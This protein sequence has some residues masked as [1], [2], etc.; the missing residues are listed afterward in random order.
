MDESEYIDL[1]KKCTP[2]PPM[3]K[4]VWSMNG[5][6]CIIFIEF[7]DLEIMETNLHNLCNIY[8]GDDNASICII[9]SRLNE[10]TI[11]RVT[12][13]WKNVHYVVPV[14]GNIDVNKYSSMLCSYAFWNMFSNF[15]HILINAWDSYIFKKIPESFFKYDYVG[16]PCAHFYVSHNNGLMNICSSGCKCPR[17]L[18]NPE[19]PFVDKNFTDTKTHHY[20]FNGGF[21]LRRVST[22]KNICLNKIYLG[23]PEDLYFCLN[24]INKPLTREEACEFAIQDYRKTD[25]LPVGTHKVWVHND[26]N[27]VKSL[28]LNFSRLSA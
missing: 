16:A 24:K 4:C 23:E 2:K 14:G 5:K 17:C 10:P 28:F 13:N 19:H 9:H 8:G 27:Y 18:E 3:E 1:I 11:R 7:R 25:E 22:M 26:S 12:E 20:L 15:E 21:S 6:L